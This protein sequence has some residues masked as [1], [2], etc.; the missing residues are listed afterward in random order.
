MQM[1]ATLSP[2]LTADE[3]KRAVYAFDRAYDGRF[4]FAVTSTGIFCFPSCP[5]RR[6]R[7][8]HLR[9]FITREAALAAGFRPCKRCC[10]DLDGGRRAYEA[11]LIARVDARLGASLETAT[12]VALAAHV[13]LSTPYLL[14]LWQRVTGTSLPEAIRRRRVERAALL[15]A[16]TDLPV[17][18]VG[19]AVG[20]ASQSAFYAA[21]L[22][23]LGE[24]PAQYRARCRAG[25]VPTAPAAPPP[26]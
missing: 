7:P 19:L 21:C 25:L 3:M 22:R 5:A 20:F 15:L 2:A 10:S 18:D 24:P 6:P 12:P 9:L 23:M 14:R 17:L 16:T 26:G 4:F 8:E 1:T 11:D 13:G